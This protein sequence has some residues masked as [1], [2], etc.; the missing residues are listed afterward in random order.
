MGPPSVFYR[1]ES[2]DIVCGNDIRFPSGAQ[3]SIDMLEQIERGKRLD[4]PPWKKFNLTL[5]II[6]DISVSYSKTITGMPPE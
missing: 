3:Y 5:G 4:A 6:P 1:W 2:R